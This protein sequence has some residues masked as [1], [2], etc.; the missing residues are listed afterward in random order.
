[1]INLMLKINSYISKKA[2]FYIRSMIEVT[3]FN[4]KGF[5]RKY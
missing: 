5:N 2:V 4:S 3:F 1:M